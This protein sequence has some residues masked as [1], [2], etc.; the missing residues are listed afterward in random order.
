MLMKVH[1]FLLGAEMLHREKL[2]H[3][4]VSA[5]CAAQ[6]L[7]VPYE[8]LRLMLQ[9]RVLDLPSEAPGRGKERRLSVAEIYQI[10]LFDAVV[11][12][13]RG[14]LPRAR[15]IVERLL[16]PEPGELLPA[17]FPIGEPRSAHEK[18]RFSRSGMKL[19]EMAEDL[20]NAPAYYLHRGPHPRYLL[21]RKERFSVEVAPFSECDDVRESRINLTKLFGDLDAR[22]LA[23]EDKL[24]ERAQA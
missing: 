17:S 9:R 14:S 5:K 23:L 1:S 7:D 24:R 2:R 21:L 6:L 13:G 18:A 8:N 16:V 22:I 15:R 19:Q 10:S 12:C 11:E 3:L 4:T 20:L